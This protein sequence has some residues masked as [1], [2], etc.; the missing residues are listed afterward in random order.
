MTVNKWNHF[1]I[2][3]TSKLWNSQTKNLNSCNKILQ[4]K[5][6]KTKRLWW[7][8]HL[9]MHVE[10]PKT[11]H[12]K[13]TEVYLVQNSWELIQKLTLLVF[14]LSIYLPPLMNIVKN[15]CLKVDKLPRCKQSNMNQNRKTCTTSLNLRLQGMIQWVLEITLLSNPWE[16]SHLQLWIMQISFPRTFFIETAI[17]IKPE[18][19]V[20]WSSLINLQHVALPHQARRCQLWFSCLDSCSPCGPSNK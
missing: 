9:E 18:S 15:Q 17:K 2:I 6:V 4:H 13:G 7:C 20:H 8:K 16:E 1:R 14:I 19:H 10:A 5:K 12:F 11:C 3:Q